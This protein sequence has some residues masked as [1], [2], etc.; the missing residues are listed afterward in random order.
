M[1]WVGEEGEIELEE[2]VASVDQICAV[3]EESLV[4]L[5]C[6]MGL[7]YCSELVWQPA[8]QQ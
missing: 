3:G 2:L 4:H 1:W 7:R 5:R 8:S 6:L